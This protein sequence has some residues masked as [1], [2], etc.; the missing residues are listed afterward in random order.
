MSFVLP[1]GASGSG[2]VTKV[3]PAEAEAEAEEER[4][5]WEMVAD[6]PNALYK[7]ATGG[8][9]EI[10]FPDIPESTEIEDIGFFEG[11]APNLKMM[12]AR[13][14]TGKAEIL[15]NSFQGD[16]RFGGVF[17]D[18]YNHPM[19][20]WNDQPYYIN[21]PG[22]SG[23]DLGTFIGEIV[24]YSPATKFVS[25]AKRILPIIQRGASTY[26][27]TEL[28]SQAGEAM[29]APETAK[30]K[31]KTATDIAEETALATGIGVGADLVVP[32]VLKPAAR[33]VRK[34]TGAAA[35]SIFPRYA[36]GIDAVVDSPADL[37]KSKYP[38]TVGQREAQPPIRGPEE[39]VTP[40]LQEE[41]VIRRSPATDPDASSILRAFDQKQIDEIRADA[42]A[43]K[44]EFG[45]GDPAVRQAEYPADASAEQIQSIASGRAAA[46]KSE[47][48]AAYKAVR[49]AEV[50]PIFSREGIVQTVGD[51]INSVRAGELRMTAREV[52]S[53]PVLTRELE[54]LK[55]LGKL[56]SNPKFKGQPLTAIHGYQKTL[57]RAF[58]QAEKGSP[59]QLALGK[60]KGVIDKAVFDG[61]EQGIITGD[62]AILD[63]LKSATDLYRQ[64]IG[65]TGKG[66]GKN[67]Q[68]KSANKIL[69]MITDPDYNPVQ[70]SRAI[71]GHAKF[72]PSQSMGLV[73]DKLKAN[74]P[75]N[76]AA[77]IIAL[78]KDGVLEKAFSGKGKSGVTRTN[79]VNNFS[80]VF[81]KQKAIINRLFSPEEIAR[82][83]QFKDDV[84]PTMWADIKLNPPG[85][86]YLM[87]AALGKSKIL[88]FAKMVPF[89]G[90][91]ISEGAEGL[92]RAAQ[93]SQAKDAVRQYVVRSN[94]PLFSAPISAAA[95][96]PAISEDVDAS[97][98]L[99]L[100]SGMSD[101]AKQKVIEAV[102]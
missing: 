25:G 10:E 99:P 89:V 42:D 75:E 50:Q 81:V 85:T 40:Q 64:Y 67:S 30:T 5:F 55:R 29:L 76:D 98:V 86:A 70:V 63:Q 62:Q 23:Q 1:Q 36:P 12:M 20:V 72:N 26:P 52:A 88:S 47:S 83:S 79:I 68:H 69:E 2:S 74:L 6:T 3:V 21:K 46:L 95:R 19:V 94:M 53:M 71:L 58:R 16:P 80:D 97:A 38:L 34:A 90:Q 41:D 44:A 18:K 60:M 102:Q 14:D 73:I 78:I 84:L 96:P 39:R 33:V 48:G 13:D 61:I 101:A 54:Y 32:G 87:L 31:E 8:G 65:L 49:D 57:N 35:K 82:I 66:A 91:G 77:E 43:L 92:G 9:V 22:F 7:A 17:S 24:K 59:E 51:V 28:A 56:A 27:A 45:S 100:A 93:A 15:R 4:S 11:I 37:S